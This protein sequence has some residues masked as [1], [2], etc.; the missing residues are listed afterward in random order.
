M[1]TSRNFVIS[2][3]LVV[4]VCTAGLT[5]LFLYSATDLAAKACFQIAHDLQ[6]EYQKAN[7]TFAPD[8]SKLEKLD[9]TC[10]ARFGMRVDL[11]NASE[12]VMTG[13]RG[14]KKFSIDQNREWKTF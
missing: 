3:I 12:F 2:L 5:A 11:I 8:L 7:L 6:M 9:P 13:A 10:T 4:T 14:A 1:K